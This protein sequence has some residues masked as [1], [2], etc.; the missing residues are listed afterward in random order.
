VVRQ[1]GFVPVCVIRFDENKN[2]LI[3]MNSLMKTKKY[4]SYFLFEEEVIKIEAI[5]I[6]VKNNVKKM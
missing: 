1:E 3:N 2:V 5:K 6:I 4:R